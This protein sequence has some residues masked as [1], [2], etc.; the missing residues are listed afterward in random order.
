VQ[1][2]AK[3]LISLTFAFT[4]GWKMTLVI[5]SLAP[6][7]WI[8]SIISSKVYFSSFFSSNNR[9]F[10]VDNLQISEKMFAQELRAYERAGAIAEE[11]FSNVRT[12]FA[13]NGTQHEQMR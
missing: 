10:F 7:I 5:L 6:F 1:L 4:R 11:V 8:V 3:F 12:V 13:F 2:C 9:T